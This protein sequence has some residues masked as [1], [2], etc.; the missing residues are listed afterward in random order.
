MESTST[1]VTPIATP[2]T[3]RP[4]SPSVR[5]RHPHKPISGGR[6]SRRARKTAVSNT[7]PTASSGDETMSKPTKSKGPN[8]KMRKWHAEGLDDEDG[9]ITLDYSAPTGGSTRT[10]P[11]VDR[12]TS[13][14]TE[15]ID[16]NSW[17][18]RTGKGDFVLKDLDDEI[19]SIIAQSR[20]KTAQRSEPNSKIGSGFN[21]LGDFFKNIVKGKIIAKEDLEKPLKNMEVHLLNK[22]VAREAAVRLCS[23]VEHDLIGVKIDSFSSKPILSTKN[24]TDG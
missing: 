9:E 5:E 19:D 3:S 1:D 18:K 10:D 13:K 17:G 7:V 23:S 21:A 8:K 6:L 11:N 14:D 16:P 22:N 15:M 12:V 4:S 24:D 20:E 2:D